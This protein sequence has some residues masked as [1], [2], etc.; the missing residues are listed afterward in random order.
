[1]NGESDARLD[2]TDTHA[3]LITETEASTTKEVSFDKRE[4]FQISYL[5][6][7]WFI[8]FFGRKNAS[9][10]LTKRQSSAD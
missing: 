3:Q 2:D 7:A 5:P 9:W 6:D 8:F 4:S 1:M 10:G